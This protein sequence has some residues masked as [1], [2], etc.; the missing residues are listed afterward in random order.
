[1]K[2]TMKVK[3]KR[4]RLGFIHDHLKA[5]AHE[6][7]WVDIAKIDRLGL[8]AKQFAAELRGLSHFGLYRAG[9]YVLD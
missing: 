3:F 1:M 7:G 6:D 9:G 8:S 2:S 4:S 5:H